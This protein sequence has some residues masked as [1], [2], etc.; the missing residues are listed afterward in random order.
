M[1]N[2][3]ARTYLTTRNLFIVSIA[4]A[5]LTVVAVWLLGLGR[6]ST[7]FENSLLSTT[8]LSAAFFLF[9]SI[10]LYKGVKLKDN[11]GRITDRI[12]LDK[13]SDLSGKIELPGEIPDAGEGLGG[14]ILGI[15]GWILV[16]ILLL[17]FIWVFGAVM[18]VA[19]LSFAAMLYWI[20]FRALRLVFRHSYQCRHNLSASMTYALAYTLLYNCWIYGI[21]LAAHYLVH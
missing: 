5:V 2:K 16:A 21:I 8:I 18:W 12:K 6:H 17:I 13:L 1:R 3:T 19:I 15:L 7:L 10:G 20:F 11:L 9:L 14:I 4:V